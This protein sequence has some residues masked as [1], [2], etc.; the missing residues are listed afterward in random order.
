[1]ASIISAVIFLNAERIATFTGDVRLIQTYKWAAF[2]FLLVPFTVL[3]RGIFQG[4]LLMKPIA[5]SQVGEQ[6]VRVS[7]IILGAYLFFIH[8]ISIDQI[9][10]V[11]V[12][13]SILGA[14]SV[15][16]M[17]GFYFRKTALVSQERYDIPWRYYIRT[18]C[19]FGVVASMNHMVLLI[20]QFADVF[21]L[22]PHLVD[23][24]LSEIEAMAAKGVLDRGQPLI[25]LGTVLGS[26]FA[27]SVI[28]TVT[29]TNIR[30]RREEMMDYLQNAMLFSF[31]LAAGAMV[32][33]ILIFPET[34]V[35]LFQDGQGTFSLQIIASAVLL[36]SLAITMAAILQ[37]IGSF[38]RTA[39]YIVGAFVIKWIANGLFVP[40]WGI[41]GGAFATVFSLLLLTV[42]LLC[43]LKRQLPGA[44]LFYKINWL[45]FVVAGIGMS[46]F[47]IIIKFIMPFSEITSRVVLLVY[48]ISI[49]II[50]AL[51]YF[52]FLLRFRAFTEKE[53]RMLPFHELWIKLHKGRDVK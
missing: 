41:T 43:E 2:V 5:V 6:L 1:M 52:V 44:K 53:L 26:S 18:L 51:I 28:P 31:Y 33:L 39:L 22:V 10:E 37:G 8:K 40:L 27:L 19:L 16:M 9:G 30:E 15:I 50:G 38:K 49:A 17:L 25:Q 14:L 11:A 12:F 21:T 4:H 35:L 47:I 34:N 3:L 24:G 46:G 36:S 42:A 13:A 29:V 32:G 48:V 7:V 23:Y 20:I 45:A